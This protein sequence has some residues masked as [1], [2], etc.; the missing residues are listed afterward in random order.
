MYLLNRTIALSL[1][2]R[3]LVVLIALLTIGYG[4]RTATVTPVDVFP[5]FAPVQ[6]EV[7]TE[8]PGYAPDEI[9]NLITLPL[10]Q[11]LGGTAK[12]KMVRSLSTVGLSVI[13]IIFEDGTNV[14]TARQLVQERLQSTRA[15]LPE[16]VGEPLLAPIA[17]IT[18][19]ILKIAFIAEAKTTAMELRTLADWTVP[20]QNL[21][22]A[23]SFKCRHLWR[24]DQAVS[25]LVG[26]TQVA[27]LQAVSQ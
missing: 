24:G 12:S 6:V 20:A 26:S 22:C 18:G 2:H 9:E 25:D 27:A 7:L 23:R 11:A 21:G 17:T 10:E 13:T 15:K 14:F 8:A 5:D 1:Q 4:I 19:D 3:W 16:S